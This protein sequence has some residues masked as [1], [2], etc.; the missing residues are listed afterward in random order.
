[1]LATTR[2]KVLGAIAAAATAYVLFGQRD[3]PTADLATVPSSATRHS[4]AIEQ[5]PRASGMRL[6]YLL[7]HRVA[8][9]STASSLF[10]AHSWYVAP[11]PPPAPPPVAPT[12]TA[13]P[14]P[15][16]P[17][18]PFQYIG[19]YKPDGEAQVFF[20]MH[21]DR[22]YDVRVG[23]TLD[24]TYSVTGFNGTQLLFNYKPLNIQ[25]QLSAGGAP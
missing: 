11:P 6:L 19:S 20:L 21:G 14:A 12:A 23:E 15:T 4:P 7:T 22:V 5:L 10:A 3:P 24:N 18:L 16:V 2:L 1:M 9:Q 13:P 8:D 17:P 25:Q